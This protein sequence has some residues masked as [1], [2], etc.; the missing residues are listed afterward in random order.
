MSEPANDP[1]NLTVE[2]VSRPVSVSNWITAT[3]GLVAFIIALFTARYFSKELNMLVDAAILVILMTGL[4]IFSVD[5]FINK[6]HLRSSTGLDFK[7]S[8]YSLSRTGYKL[9]GLV[10]IL[11]ILS[12]A[13]WLF[14]EYA[15]DFYVDYFIFL[16]KVVPI[17]VL[18]AIPYFYYIDSKQ[19]D[20]FDGYWNMGK[21]IAGDWEEVN[22]NSLK[23][24]VLGW[25]IK[26]FFLP[27]MFTFL[28]Q[29]LNA[30]IMTDFSKLTTFNAGF[31]FAYTFLYLIDVGL[32][33]VGY[34]M[35][36]RLMDTHLRSAEPTMLGWASALFCYDPFWI[37]IGAKF[38]AYDTS[39]KWN[40]WLAND[41][42]MFKIWALVILA[43]VAIYVWATVIFGARFSNLTH[44]GIITNGPFKYTKHPAY[45]SKNFSWW[46]INIPFIVHESIDYSNKHCLLLLGINFIYYI[47][48]KTEEQH[49]MK[50]PVY[51]QYAAWIDQHGIFRF[52][53]KWK[54]HFKLGKT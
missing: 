45:L 18:V 53:N 52:V 12:V 36:L 37:A 39:Y 4:G 17:S 25:I 32:V 49:L 41:P 50:D 51:A 31:D 47:R 21:F 23:Q 48:A 20:P 10:G 38:L 5:F 27:L 33:P 6:V 29:N 54:P 19:T 11:S 28:C 1:S 46:L 26:A 9:L 43:L 3:A 13:Y 15:S 7:Q 24:F 40:D 44:R 14:P 2:Q 42:I 22:P 34:I 16:K 30:F 8:N 35:S